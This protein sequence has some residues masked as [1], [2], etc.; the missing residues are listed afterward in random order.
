MSWCNLVSFTY[1]FYRQMLAPESKIMDSKKTQNP[2]DIV[3]SKNKTK[4]KTC[5]KVKQKHYE[6]IYFC[7]NCEKYVCNDCYKKS[8]FLLPVK[9][10]IYSCK[11]QDE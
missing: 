8:R 6:T 11:D 7:A 2:I 9:G 1:G 5:D 10:S 4:C 3:E